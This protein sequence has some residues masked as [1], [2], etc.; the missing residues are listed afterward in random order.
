MF[1]WGIAIFLAAIVSRKIGNVLTLLW[2]QVFGLLV[3]LI[4][5]FPN[6]QTLYTTRLYGSLPIIAVI[7]ILQLI[8]YLA[9][10]KGLER[11]QVSLVSPLGASWGLISAVL[12]IIFYHERFVFHQGIAILFILG[13]IVGLSIDFKKLMASKELSV[14]AGVKEGVIAMFAWGISLFLLVMP[15]KAVNWFLPTLVFRLLLILFLGGYMVATKTSFIPKKEKVP[16]GSLFV[17][18][19]FD[20]AAFMSLSLG[21]LQANSSLI[22]PIASAYALV[23]VILAWLVLKEKM[24]LRHIASALAIVAGIVGMSI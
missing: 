15:T 4:Y 11:G 7:A 10:Y 13:G 17:I 2:M 5:L 23:T 19:A 14:L 6:V 8:A 9:F 16:W 12:G 20:F 18:G 1:C 22:L 21:E 3:G 24:T